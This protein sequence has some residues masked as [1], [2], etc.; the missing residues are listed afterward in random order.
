MCA[1]CTDTI[2]ENSVTEQRL[3]DCKTCHTVF[4]FRCAKAWATFNLVTLRGEEGSRS[5]TCPTCSSSISGI[6]TVSCWCGKR[7]FIL[8]YT[9]SGSRTANS[10]GDTCGK[11]KRC[12]HGTWIRCGEVCHPGPC[13]PSCTSC[14]GHRY[15][16][17]K[18][19]NLYGRL[20]ERLSKRLNTPLMKASLLCCILGCVYAV[21]GLLWYL[22]SRWWIQPFRYSTH[23]LTGK[24]LETYAALVGAIVLGR[25]LSLLV[26]A[27]VDAVRDVVI[28]VLDLDTRAIAASRE[29]L[30]KK[31]G[32]CFLNTIKLALCVP[33]IIG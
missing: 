31:L 24:R 26:C 12:T 15:V 27:S 9:I 17:P 23:N 3:W 22:Y 20:Q 4:H 6:P 8:G 1:I 10:C 11:L 7:N 33:P 29:R 19:P 25:P 21:V 18:K 14:E 2:T 30:A 13:N 16:E 28:H 5:W 32:I